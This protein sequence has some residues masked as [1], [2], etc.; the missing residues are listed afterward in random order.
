VKFE[1]GYFKRA[2]ICSAFWIE[3]F[4][5]NED[6]KT[7]ASDIHHRLA[8]C[9]AQ[10]EISV[11]TDIPIHTIEHTWTHRGK[12]TWRFPAGNCLYC[13]V[14]CETRTLIN[15]LESY[16]ILVPIRLHDIPPDYHIVKYLYISDEVRKNNLTATE[17]RNVV[18]INYIINIMQQLSN[19]L[20][21]VFKKPSTGASRK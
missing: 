18:P 6:F 7:M 17:R 12:G 5:I 9:H 8:N 13:D 3:T 16:K 15:A 1:A 20:K 2:T 4:L 10:I 19:R 21:N 11:C 14:V